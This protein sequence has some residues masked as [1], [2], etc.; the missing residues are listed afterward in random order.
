MAGEE[1]Y[2]ARL[3]A[4]LARA[5]GDSGSFAVDL[6]TDGV[7]LQMPDAVV[8]DAAVKAAGLALAESGTVLHDGADKLDSAIETAD[9]GQLVAAFVRLFEG[10]YRFVDSMKAIVDRIG[11]VAATLPPAERDA[12]AAFGLLMARKAIDYLVV[13]VLEQQL[14]R[15]LFLFK[16]LGLVEWSV[17]EE[18]PARG[19]PRF[20]KKELHLERLKDLFTDPA[21]HFARV[22][23]WGTDAF[24]PSDIFRAVL[25]F[26]HENASIE[27]GRDGADAFLRT[28]PF[29]WKR[30]SAPLPGHPP[31][32][33]PG[34]LLDVSARIAH[35]FAQRV[36]F[37]S[38]W[39][40]D[41]QADLAFS[42]GAI[43][44]LRPPFE[45]SVE[46]KEGTASGAFSF[47]VNRNPTA[48][49]FT[50]VGG[51][52]L[53]RLVADD[54]GI[55]AELTVGATT[56]GVFTV[57]PGV[58]AELKGL[59]LSLGTA[60]S[61]N[62]LASLLSEAD[63]R[64]VFDIG[65][66]WKLSEGLVVR[67]A[68][69]LEIAIPMHQNL[70]I[71]TLETLYVILKLREDGSFALE[72]SATI[73]GHLGPLQAAV[74]RMGVELQIA[75]AE[76]AEAD[77]G[78]LD[79]DLAFKP[80]SG[81]GLSLD[82]GVV[83]GG[84]YLF[85]DYEKGE[86]AG[87]LEL[88]FS[89]IIAVKAIGLISTKMPDGSDGFSLLVIVTAEFGTPFQLGFG[90]TLIGLGGL[91]GLNRTM[92][93]EVLAEGVRSGSIENIMFPRNVVANAPQILSDM[94]R[95]FP[96]E[97]GTFL[98]APMAKLG[99]GSPALVTVS[100]GVI[101]EA[102]PGNIAILG[103]IK[104]SLP[105]EEHALLVLKV[106]FIGALEVDK[107]RLWFFASLFESRVLFITIG[108]EMG[109][110]IAWGSEPA[111]VLSVGGFHPSF[112]P[113]PLPFPVPQRISLSIL[114]ESWARVRVEAYFAVTS[115]TVQFGA[116]VDL[117]FGVDAFAVEG[118]LG[119]DALF[120]FSPFK[121]SISFAAGLSVRVFGVNLLAIRFRGL[122]EGPTPWHI[123]G[124]ASISILFFDIHV[125]FSHTWGDV[126]GDVL[127]SIPAM[128][129]LVGELEKRENW[130][131]LPPSGGSISVSLR[132]IEE[133]ETL[134]LHPVGTL[135]VSQRAIPLDVS[136][137]KV[138]NQKVSDVTS[139]TVTVGGTSL[140]KKADVR[141]PFA[142]AQF[143]EMAAADKLSA[144]AYEDRNAGIVISPSGSDTRTSHAVKRPV[145]HELV[146]I[147]ESYKEHV[148]PL[149][150][151]GLAWFGRLL[152]G[153]AIARS[154]LS[155]ASK[156]A[157]VPFSQKV[158]ASAPGFVIARASDNAPLAAAATFGS[159]AEAR[160]ALAAHLRA[161]PAA[162]GDFHVIP[163][164]EA[165][166][167]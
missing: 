48:R 25:T 56:S 78:P 19:Q 160:D 125:P 84:G 157:K 6:D 10:V 12:V 61:D 101:I 121:L 107:S 13:S 89:G 103:V 82:A 142:S 129:I 158:V 91:L 116:R 149:F 147:D 46:P 54:V 127:P 167:A 38:A 76:G 90:F 57:D 23:Q 150:N 159:H 98:I 52:E 113:P 36:S 41:F 2:V 102:P 50:I 128:P 40:T 81:V 104:C 141:E 35:T 80:P 108:G 152:T 4:W 63:V 105:D 22:Y 145:M 140:R 16:L 74:E 37:D 71:A 134:V 66:G 5:L 17:V 114:N 94:R 7:G 115:N 143:R 67:A 68:G 59:T 148:R 64:G 43:F 161:N 135:R 18:D 124:E 51:N 30:D 130:V 112:T 44:R 155:V 24:D 70:G 9:N 3:G 8:N 146:T 164:A 72:T 166:A 106:K 162:A 29:L 144:P 163:K 27:V 119:F 47:K 75:F 151:A 92:M 58:F 111:F 32:L 153:N 123:E 53:I 69:G 99:W 93:L 83:R 73:T 96:A 154:P 31:S 11:V 88:V 1:I 132:T 62:F 14:P 39:G 109:L 85:F 79:L 133:T 156:R 97:Q 34:V 28:G 20:V 15:L 165:K 136:L 122:L 139:A 117:F 60:G 95:F 118:Y 45:I 65:L 137:E 21:G 110:L 42:G 49:G 120:Q 26:Y 55:G 131:A 33:P 138:G 77:L 87:A 126:A 86:Y 100:L